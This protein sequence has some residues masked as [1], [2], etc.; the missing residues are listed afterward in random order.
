MGRRQQRE[1]ELEHAAS[2]S[3]KLETFFGPDP[4]KQK[5][6][7]GTTDEST[8]LPASTPSDDNATEHEKIQDPTANMED[9][10]DLPNDIG[11]LYLWSKTPQQFCNEILRLTSEQKYNLLSQHTKPIPGKVFPIQVLGGCNRSFR[12]IWLTQHPWMVYSD[13][14]DGVFCIV[15]AI[16]ASDPLKGTFVTRPFRKWQKKSEK[17]KEHEH[18][19]YH[20]KSLEMA[21]QFKQSIEKPDT[22]ITVRIDNQRALNIRRNREIMKS[23]ARA[24]LFCGRQCIALRGDRESLETTGN[25]GNFI[26]LLKL[27]AL[28]DETLRNHLS[29]PAM[30]CATGISPSTQNELIEIMGKHIILKSILSEIKTSPYY[31]VMADEV[32]SHNIEHLA[33]CARFVDDRKDIREEFLTF[34]PLERITGEKIAE[35]ILSFLSDNNIPV[36][37]MRGQGYDG[38]GN[39]SSCSVGVQAR[40]MRE[41][42]LATYV[43]CNSH[44]LNLVISKSCALPQIRNVMDRLKDCCNYFLNS[45]KRTGALELVVK[46]NVL[47]VGKRKPLLDLC[48]TR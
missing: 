44:C 23:I 13:K 26:A 15:C 42:P 40:I 46:H 45:P 16:F 19:S 29:S 7:A 39:M 35:N 8:E 17:A 47:D 31:A 9:N 37:N 4:K 34:L 25:P 41:S 14:V 36:T 33:I 3:K 38:A 32:T 22:T 28:T 21:N 48:K 6:G 20:Q 43:H 10:C 12:E 30:K 1:R 18:C 5:T 2:S 24:V 11:E 27:M